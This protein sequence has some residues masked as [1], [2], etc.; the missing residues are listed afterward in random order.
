MA[1]V[2]TVTINASGVGAAQSGNSNVLQ[3]LAGVINGL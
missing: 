2:E 1:T 3:E